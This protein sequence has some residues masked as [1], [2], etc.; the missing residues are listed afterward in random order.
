MGTSALMLLPLLVMCASALPLDAAGGDDQGSPLSLV[1]ETEG[2]GAAPNVPY[3]GAAQ[4]ATAN[5][6]ALAA[7]MKEHEMNVQAAQREAAEDEEVSKQ[8]ESMSS[9]DVGKYIDDM[10]ASQRPIDVMAKQY[11]SLAIK[12]SDTRKALAAAEV[13]EARVATQEA[14]MKKAAQKSDM[15]DRGVGGKLP[16]LEGMKVAIKTTI[17]ANMKEAMGD[18]TYPGEPSWDSILPTE[19]NFHATPE[20]KDRKEAPAAVAAQAEQAMLTQRQTAIAHKE[21]LLSEEKQMLK[22]QML[23]VAEAANNLQNKFQE[24][25][26]KTRYKA[27]KSVHQAQIEMHEAQ[28]EKAEAGVDTFKEKQ[29]EGLLKKAL[30]RAVTDKMRLQRASASQAAQMKVAAESQEAHD[31]RALKQMSQG[32]IKSMAA[33]ATKIAKQLFEAKR[34][35]KRDQATISYLK[36][37]MVLQQRQN[38]RRQGQ[39]ANAVEKKESAF[40][41]KQMSNLRT[42][43]AQSEG[44]LNNKVSTAVAQSTKATETAIRDEKRI[45]GNSQNVA[46]KLQAAMKEQ[47]EEEQTD[48]ELARKNKRL[49][50]EYADLKHEA[51]V[52]R[53]KAAKLGAE[54]EGHRN[55]NAKLIALVHKI[56][57]QREDA[58][59][60][61]VSVA[62][63]L[64]VAKAKLRSFE[65]QFKVSADPAAAKQQYNNLMSTPCFGE[66]CNSMSSDSDKQP[67]LVMTPVFEPSDIQDTP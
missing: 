9:G 25:E 1:G 5:K 45:A 21:K 50:R 34:T 2:A 19:E 44:A 13:N 42:Q 27:Q 36:S 64:D 58:E 54:N 35:I 11:A 37:K 56:S 59:K 30:T 14:A 49:T 31:I 10:Q 33:A 3:R 39:I 41:N 28:E 57:R 15:L 17:D 46:G 6:A 48:S 20:K 62:A 38:V 32:N 60:K 8:V 18:M 53:S 43:N 63:Q 52:W 67:P 40:W 23:N 66:G 26:D 22:G 16:S 4:A 51:S 55:A 29:R 24:E 12:P 47:K 61:T 7:E 65:G